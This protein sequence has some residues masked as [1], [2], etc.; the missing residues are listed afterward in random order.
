M[1]WM[2]IKKKSL[3]RLY[4]LPWLYC[5][6]GTTRKGGWFSTLVLRAAFRTGAD[7]ELMAPWEN[8]MVDN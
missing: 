6:L 7:T 3:V 5:S 4:R 1:T 8:D 2:T